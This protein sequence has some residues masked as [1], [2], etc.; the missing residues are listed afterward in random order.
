LRVYGAALDP[1]NGNAKTI[2]DKIESGKLLDGFSAGDILRGGW[3]GLDTFEI[4]KSALSRLVE[5]GWLK[6]VTLPGSAMGGRPSIRY[7]P[8][9]KILSNTPT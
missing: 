2:L 1:V 3:T 8:H 9:P 7:Q 5:Y 4:V 6:Q